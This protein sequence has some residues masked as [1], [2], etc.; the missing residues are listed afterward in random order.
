M[1]GGKGGS[2]T[3]TIKLPKSLEEG[4][5]EVLAAGL[6]SAALPYSPNRGVTIAAFSP[7]QQAAM[8]GANSAA[9]AFG[10]PMGQGQYMPPAEVGA[11]GV[12][13]YSTGDLYD[14]NVARSMTPAEQAARNALLLSYANSAE[15]IKPDAT[16]TDTVSRA[17]GGTPTTTTTQAAS[18]NPWGDS[19]MG[20]ILANTAKKK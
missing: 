11:G 18:D 10:L 5:T 1:G 19:P 7:Q 16:F 9:G 15:R 14:Q 20:K 6:R 17:L 2:Q 3:Q 4:S 13:G 8:E 12:K